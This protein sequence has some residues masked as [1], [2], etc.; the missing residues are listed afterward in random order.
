MRLPSKVEWSAFAV[1]VILTA[2]NVGWTMRAFKEGNQGQVMATWIMFAVAE[3]LNFLFYFSTENK[4]RSWINS[5]GN[6][7]EALGCWLVLMLMLLVRGWLGLVFSFWD[8]VCLGISGSAVALWLLTG[9]TKNPQRVIQMVLTVAYIPT[10]IA[11]WTADINTQPWH[12]WGSAAIAMTISMYAPWQRNKQTGQ[13]DW[14]ALMYS[15]RAL[16]M[17]MILLALMGWKDW[18]RYL[19]A[20][21]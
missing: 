19:Y 6:I 7:E 20:L 12:F 3:S 16:A 8:L 17:L 5:A 14:R 10:F 1:V 4:E 2:V 11:V 13:R 21:I 18:G 15:A 9:K